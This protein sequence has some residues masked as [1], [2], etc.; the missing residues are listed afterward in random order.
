MEFFQSLPLEIKVVF[1]AFVAVGL[2]ALFSHNHR[3]EKYYVVV[4]VLLAAGGLYRYQSTKPVEKAVIAEE[5][6]P[7]VTPPPAHRP[8]ESAR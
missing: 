6:R 4:L 8:L 2:L 3:T 5:P 1:G 7:A